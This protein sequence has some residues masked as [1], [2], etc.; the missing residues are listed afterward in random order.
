MSLLLATLMV[1]SVLIGCKQAGGEFSGS[2]T[3]AASLEETLSEADKAT[4]KELVGKFTASLQDGDDATIHKMMSPDLRAKTPPLPQWIQTTQF[5]PLS[6]AKD[7]K[8]SLIRYSGRGKTLVVS[9]RFTGAGN[10]SYTTNFAFKKSGNSWMLNQVFPP[11]MPQSPSQ[12]SSQA[13]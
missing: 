7:W 5:A 4:A 6:G 12:S 1:S 10:N 9:T 8:T 2:S 11:T 13:K 3:A